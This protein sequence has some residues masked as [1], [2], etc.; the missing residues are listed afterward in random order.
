MRQMHFIFFKIIIVCILSLPFSQN[1]HA[2]NIQQCKDIQN[3]ADVTA[4][5]NKIYDAEQA[6]L[7]RIFERVTNDIYPSLMA[8]HQNVQAQN[9]AFDQPNLNAAAISEEQ[10]T[11]VEPVPLPAKK[12]VAHNKDTQ[13]E[14]QE[15][16]KPDAMSAANDVQIKEIREVSKNLEITLREAQKS[17]LLYR[18]DQCRWQINRSANESAKRTEELSCLI[19]LTQQRI[20]SLALFAKEENQSLSAA[21]YGVIPRWMNA[22]SSEKPAL[23]WQYNN[24]IRVDLDCDG[25]PEEI[26]TGLEI[27][28]IKPHK[29]K[30]AAASAQYKSWIAIAGNPVTG[31]AQVSFLPLENWIHKDKKKTRCISEPSLS[32]TPM[33]LPSV[34]N[35]QPPPEKVCSAYVE[36]KREGCNS[37]YLFAIDNTYSLF[38]NKPDMLKNE[39]SIS[40]E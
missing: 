31:K 22:I 6:R 33:P 17:W 11:A 36:I 5:L 4:C 12:P 40:S 14:I 35:G 15:K 28:N 3:S 26:M 19:L 13:Q 27:L 18:D 10:G 1:A 21:S 7:S 32:F 37:R 34:N 2:L 24:H 29:E 38:E 30:N 23:Y 9:D 8:R 25:Q 20:E 39:T 16:I